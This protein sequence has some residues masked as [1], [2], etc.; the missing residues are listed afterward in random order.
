MDVVAE[1]NKMV[2]K[3]VAVLSGDEEEGI[4]ASEIHLP[5]C[6][7]EKLPGGHHFDGNTSAVAKVVIG[8][9]R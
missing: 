2:V 7:I 6:A 3:K 1:I 8:Y 5:N 4:P 9:I